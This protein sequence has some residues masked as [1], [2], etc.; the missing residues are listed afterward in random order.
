[1]YIA[2]EFLGLVLISLAANYKRTGESKLNI[3]SWDF[4]YQ[5][6]LIGIGI[7][8]IVHSEIAQS[9]IK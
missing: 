2:V 5:T 6:V 4:F 8:L 3:F 1:M 9:V 7:T